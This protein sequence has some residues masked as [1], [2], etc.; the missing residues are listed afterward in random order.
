MALTSTL[1]GTSS[2]R[3]KTRLVFRHE[4]SPDVFGPFVEFRPQGVD[5]NAYMATHATAL[6]EA[7]VEWELQKNLA[8]ALIG[9][10]VPPT[11]RW[12]TAAQARA[13]VRDAYRVATSFEVCRLAWYI[14]QL[15]L[16]DNQLKNMFNVNDAQLVTL[17]A[18]LANL[19]AKYNDVS[20]EAGE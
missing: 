1:L 3:G 19:E 13:R 16:T 20:D 15:G 11:F 18:K 12:C 2:A 10:F 7:L 4:E 14:Q 9:P 6:T 8:N 17:K 5:A